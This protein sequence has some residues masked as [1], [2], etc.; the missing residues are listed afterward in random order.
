MDIY[1]E[2]TARIIDQMENGI[3][4]WQKPWVALVST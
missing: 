2:I 1:A 3:I 4:P